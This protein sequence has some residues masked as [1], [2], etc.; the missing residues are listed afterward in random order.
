MLN[1]V[2]WFVLWSGLAVACLAQSEKKHLLFVGQSAGYTHDSISHGMATLARIGETSGLFD[3][4]FRTDVDLIT[5]KKLTGNAKN[6]DYFDAVMFYTTG[7]LP[8]D[9]SQKADLLSFVREDGKGFLG[10]HSATDTLYK[11][12]EYGELIGGYFDLHPWHQEVTVRVEDR[13]FPATRHLPPTFS[14]T[15]EI[16]QFKNWSRDRVKV[17]M[18]LDPG[19]VDL[20]KKEVR[21]TDQDFAVAWYRQYGKGRVFYCSLGHRES[22]WDRPDMQKMWLEALRWA[23]Q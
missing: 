23:L 4:T 22:V 5:K 2:R 3:V 1:S 11:W 21:R 16:Y 15:D 14:I 10:T 19:S 7:E 18:S 20:T 13:T 6:L 8:L 9:A 17:L 12:P